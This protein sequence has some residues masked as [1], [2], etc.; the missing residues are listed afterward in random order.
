MIGFAE[1][2][3]ASLV[4]DDFPRGTGGVMLAIAVIE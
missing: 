4:A 1:R 2:R 3:A